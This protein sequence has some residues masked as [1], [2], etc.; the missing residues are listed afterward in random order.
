M[1]FIWYIALSARKVQE[2]R[3]TDQRLDVYALYTRIYTNFMPPNQN[4]I[5]PTR[6]LFI[7]AHYPPLQ[8]SVFAQNEY[9]STWR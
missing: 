2:C 4:Q 3:L 8:G 1:R 9:S 7:T 6:S 5:K